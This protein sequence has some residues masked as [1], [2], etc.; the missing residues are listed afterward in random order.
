MAKS[1]VYQKRNGSLVLVD[2]GIGDKSLTKPTLPITANKTI[3]VPSYK[4]G[5]GQ[6]M[7]YLEGIKCELGSFFSEVGTSGAQSTSLKIIDAVPSGLNLDIV[8]G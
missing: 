7:V 4:V 1:Q 5:A 6:V 8:M 2:F 3:T